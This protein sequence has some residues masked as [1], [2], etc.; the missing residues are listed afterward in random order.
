MSSEVSVVVPTGESWSV[1]TLEAARA[2]LAQVGFQAALSSAVQPIAGGRVSSLDVQ[3]QAPGDDSL[4]GPKRFFC[5]VP[6]DVEAFAEGGRLGGSFG[7]VSGVDLD[8]LED[9]LTDW[10]AT[11][12]EGPYRS[13]VVERHRGFQRDALYVDELFTSS[14]P[15]GDQIVFRSWGVASGGV[16]DHF[17]FLDV[18]TPEPSLMNQAKEVCRLLISRSTVLT[19]ENID[20]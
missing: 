9:A 16:P 17:V 3:P 15:G 10:T 4:G 19:E 6:G 1:L 12:R 7:V 18:F 13:V 11:H 5:A 14:A 8:E 20:A 2:P